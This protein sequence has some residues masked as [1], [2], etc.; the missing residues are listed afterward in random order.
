MS[1]KRRRAT[2]PCSSVSGGGDHDDN[3]SSTPGSGRKRRKI[4]NVPPVDTVKLAF[5]ACKCL[6][7]T[8]TASSLHV[9]V[10]IGIFYLFILPFRLLFV[11]SCSM[12]S[13]TI[14]IITGG[15]FVKFS[16]GCQNGGIW[17]RAWWRQTNNV[18][19]TPCFIKNVHLKCHKYIRILVEN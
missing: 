5:L 10:A 12:L 19:H 1:A 4:S 3:S 8:T 13:K 18:K 17:N 7:K 11:M 9:E 16:F 2:S 15:N 14:R 6:W